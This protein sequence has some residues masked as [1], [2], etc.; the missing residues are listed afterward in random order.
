MSAIF[1]ALAAAQKNFEAAR[2]QSVNGGFKSKYA[3]L[4]ACMDAV[5]EPLN[6]Q[7]VFVTQ[8][9]ESVESGV[10]IETL[11]AHESGE[12]YT[13]GKLYMPVMKHDAQGY[14]SAITYGRRYSL[15]TACGVAPEDD[16]GNAATASKPET[17]S[18]AP[19]I[20]ASPRIILSPEDEQFLSGMADDIRGM[21]ADGQSVPAL[22]MIR[23]ACLDSD[24]QIA[25]NNMLDS[26]VRSALKKAKESTQ[27]TKEVA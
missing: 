10:L 23:A 19:I 26:K 2:K 12:T 11:F 9:I 14:G 13:G 16:D 22:Q 7:G 6:D 5:R 15:L 20:P 24:Q 3:D 1:K 18:R 8:T 25:L 17:T 27:P 21:C 4:S